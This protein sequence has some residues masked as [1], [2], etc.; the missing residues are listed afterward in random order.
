MV[1]VLLS[2]G[3]PLAANLPSKRLAAVRIIP[4]A[5]M[6]LNLTIIR[7]ALEERLLKTLSV[8]FPPLRVEMMKLVAQA[9]IKEP[10]LETSDPTTVTLSLFLRLVPLQML[11]QQQLAVMSGAIP[12]AVSSKATLVGATASSP[13]EWIGPGE[14]TPMSLL[15][16]LKQQLLPKATLEIVMPLTPRGEQNPRFALAKIKGVPTILFAEIEL[17]LLGVGAQETSKMWEEKPP[18]A[19]L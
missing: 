4:L 3:V 7:L 15:L 13:P 1:Q 9:L 16:P 17:L 6:T 8:V 18:S 5:V 14:Q 10:T 2:L 19:T 12:M 11:K